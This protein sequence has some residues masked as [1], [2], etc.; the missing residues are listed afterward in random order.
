MGKHKSVVRKERQRQ[1]KVDAAE[2]WR[3]RGKLF[4]DKLIMKDEE[5]GGNAFTLCD[6]CEIEKYYDVAE[7]VSNHGNGNEIRTDGIVRMHFKFMLTRYWT[8]FR[9]I[10]TGAGR[11]SFY[12]AR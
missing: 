11:V 8:L 5:S 1:V 12:E 2:A 10:H 3:E 9:F 6:N 4:R 7:R